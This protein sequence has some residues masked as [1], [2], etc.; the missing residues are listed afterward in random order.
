MKQNLKNSK[1]RL[2]ISD[3][4]DG[5][6]GNRNLFFENLIDAKNKSK[7]LKGK[8]KI[9]NNNGHLIHSLHNEIGDSYA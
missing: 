1:F 6:W 8:N 9:Y 2:T 5:I 3:W 7:D 4:Q